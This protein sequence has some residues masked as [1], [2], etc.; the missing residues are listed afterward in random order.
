VFQKVRGPGLK[1]LHQHNMPTAGA[2]TILLKGQL[3]RATKAPRVGNVYFSTSVFVLRAE[4][5]ICQQRSGSSCRA[6]HVSWRHWRVIVVVVVVVVVIIIIIIIID[7]NSWVDHRH[8]T[9]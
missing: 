4:E 9:L 2:S 8:L 6:I 3:Q 1:Q 5:H 7:L